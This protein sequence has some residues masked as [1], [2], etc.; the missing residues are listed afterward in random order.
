MR[1]FTVCLLLLLAQVAIALPSSKPLTIAE[2]F[3]QQVQQR[4]QEREEERTRSSRGGPS[5]APAALKSPFTTSS[6]TSTRVASA[7]ASGPPSRLPPPLPSSQA[8]GPPHRSPPPPPPSTVSKSASVG[9]GATSSRSKH[10]AKNT[11]PFSS[12]ASGTPKHDDV[13]GTYSS[14]VDTD[15]QQLSNHQKQ[16][17]EKEMERYIKARPDG[18]AQ[19]KAGLTGATQSLKT[20]RE[21]VLPMIGRPL[22]VG[23]KLSAYKEFFG[24]AEM[25]IQGVIAMKQALQ[26]MSESAEKAKLQKQYEE[27]D[28]SV[29]GVL[30]QAYA[31]PVSGPI[32]RQ[33]QEWMKRNKVET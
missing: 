1:S 5:S 2:K 24:Y 7:H 18:K 16:V 32:L 13:G 20:L 12:S 31:N 26:V 3:Q 28:N 21:Q 15:F 10:D 30:E 14:F 19:Y 9:S 22:R 11:G 17:R 33:I 29:K 4:A 25:A 23:D 6:G 8:S 27:M